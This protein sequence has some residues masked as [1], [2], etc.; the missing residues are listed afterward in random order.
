[1]PSEVNITHSSLETTALLA[2]QLPDFVVTSTS[3][4]KTKRELLLGSEPNGTAQ[5]GCTAK[6]SDPSK[7]SSY[8]SIIGKY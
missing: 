5:P 4:S 7:Q 6:P 2:D 1:M 3:G 8:I